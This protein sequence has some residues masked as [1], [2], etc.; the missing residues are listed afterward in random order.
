MKSLARFLD[1]FVDSR[2]LVVG[3]LMLDEYLW[4]HIERISPEAPVPVFHLIRREHALGGAGNVICNLCSL[5]AKV[6]AIGVVG[7]DETGSQIL[8]QLLK[9]G[10]DTASVFPD[11]CRQSTRK[12]RLMSLDH[13][14]QVFRLD[15]E[16][17][18]DVTPEMEDRL[19]A[20]IEGKLAAAQAVVCSD[21]QKGLLTPRVLEAVLR[22]ARALGIPAIVA[23]KD[24]HAEK[25]RGASILM[26]NARELAQLAGQRLENPDW[27]PDAARRVVESLG[28]EALVVT[29]GRDGI[30]LFE[31]EAS[32]LRRV[33]IPT[34][35]RTVY[36]VTGAG[37]TA[38][39]AFSMALVAGA[40]RSEAAILAN[41]A[42]GVVVAKRGTATVTIPEIH[43]RI[44]EETFAG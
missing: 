8:A 44:A 42:A 5:G 7:R 37:D 33:D 26:P 35:A 22:V 34:L 40:D 13:D 23:P 1:A 10:V 3:D 25:Y 32:G 41:L 15:E 12:S 9:L 4:G 2:L 31:Q 11:H 38:I 21:Y 39:A 43:A 36:D 16:S 29:R 6:T 24:S 19:I 28:L 27:L 17:A 14:Q 30:S 20:S 18:R